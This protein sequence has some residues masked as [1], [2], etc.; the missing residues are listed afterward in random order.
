M[1]DD[2]LIEIDSLLDLHNMRHNLAGTS[3]KGSSTTSVGNSLGCPATVCKGYELMQDLDFDG[4]DNDGS[5][6]SVNGDGEYILDFG[7]SQADYFPVD[8]NGEGGW[9]PIGDA[10][11]PFAAVFDGNGNAISNLAISRRQTDI[12]LFAAIGEGAAIRNLGLIDNLARYPGSSND[13]VNIGGLVGS[14]DG[15]SITA[16]YATGAA[17]SGDG[18]VNAVGGLVGSQGGGSITASYAT[19]PA[20]GGDGD[21]DYVGGLVGYQSFVGS[22]TASYARGAAAGGGGNTNYVGGLVGWSDL[23]SIT[24]S[25]ATG[26]AAGGSSTNDRV[27]ELVGLSTGLILAS[28]GFGETTGGGQLE[29]SDGSGELEGVETGGRADRQQ[30]LLVLLE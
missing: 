10:E 21:S 3:Y 11:D 25:Y 23:G 30:C 22:I 13:R 15:G 18:N 20:A 9:E 17:A 1:D 26:P 6:W 28:Y 2:G 7:D 14:N 29:G 5:T 16:S 8:E 4:D 24:A 27:G 19:G 12:G